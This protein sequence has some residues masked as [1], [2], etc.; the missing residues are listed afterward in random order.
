M[1]FEPPLVPARLVRRYKRF[2]ADVRLANGTETT[3]HCAN[4]GSMLGCMPTGARVWLSPNRNPRAKLAWR[5]ELVEIEG[6]LVGINTARTNRIVEAAL[7]RGAIAGLRGYRSLRREVP[8][9][10][11]SRVD[12]VLENPGMCFLE[13]KNV[14]L[15][16]DGEAQFPDAVTARG[17][18]HLEELARM[19][20]A[21]HRAVMLY[22]VQRDDCTRFGIASDI[23]PAYAAA[24]AAAQAQGVEMLAY[25]C[26]VTTAGVRLNRPLPIHPRAAYLDEKRTDPVRS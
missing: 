10:N 4:P 7:A 1:A 12:F 18:R 3:A 5:W 11:R 2:L 15:G 13:V 16:R 19:V 6:T 14:T 17:R 24:F 20:A 25:D 22:L 26:H 21:G 8:Y 9:G 23:D